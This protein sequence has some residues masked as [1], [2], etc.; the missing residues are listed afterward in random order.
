M[1]I[2]GKYVENNMEKVEN[3]YG[4]I[5]KQSRSHLTVKMVCHGF[6]A[7]FRV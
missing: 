7:F 5:L 2:Y 6:S 3:I 4:S 1:E